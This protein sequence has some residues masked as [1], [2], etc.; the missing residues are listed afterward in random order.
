MTTALA[1][2]NGSTA[3]EHREYFS[4]EQIQLITDVIARN[5]SEA[6]LWLFIRTCERLR[7]DP[8]ARQI[9]AVKR[10]DNDLKRE[11]MQTQVSIDGFRVV[12]ERTG[13]Y[14]G[15]T[16]PQWCGLD[17]K[18]RDVWLAN[19]PPA[20]ARV[21]IFRRGF[22]EPVWGIAAYESFVQR[23]KDGDAMKQWRTM[24]DVML[25]KCAEAQALRR[26][27]PHDLGGVYAPEE[28]GQADNHSAQPSR[29]IDITAKNEPP[30]REQHREPPP[31]KERQ[32]AETEDGEIVEVPN[33]FA[34]IRDDMEFRFFARANKGVLS[35]L[36]NGQRK[37]AQQKC[38]EAALRV[39]LDPSLARALCGL[40]DGDEVR[41]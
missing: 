38:D 13:Q 37:T 39:Q 4:R 16:A 9:F 20:A 35:G 15:Q 7:L 11:V 41:P 26:A 2:V 17:G 8:F 29:V 10:W 14:E 33:T 6:E 30:P 40:A 27:F 28:M 5:A 21:G 3:I 34:E 32:I 31:P 24:P 25:L 22:R 18:W 1:N 19:E 23:K 12:A 36:K